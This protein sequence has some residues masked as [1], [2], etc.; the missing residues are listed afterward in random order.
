MQPTKIV[1]QTATGVFGDL[2]LGAKFKRLDGSVT[3]MRTQR[4]EQRF[5]DDVNAVRMDNGEMVLFDDTEKVLVDNAPE[6]VPVCD[7]PLGS[8]CIWNGIFHK[9]VD[10]KHIALPTERHILA[11]MDGDRKELTG[12]CPVIPVYSIT[13]EVGT[14]TTK[15]SI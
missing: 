11:C 13:L 9:K 4:M 8:Y 12:T 3:F 6:T 5:D 2:P 10:H 15:M 14:V 7:I 1:L